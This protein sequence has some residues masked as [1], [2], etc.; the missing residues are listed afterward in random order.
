MRSKPGK[1]AISNVVA[2][3]KRPV[4]VHINV[5]VMLIGRYAWTF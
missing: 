1:L 4:D 5:H 2:S 3:M